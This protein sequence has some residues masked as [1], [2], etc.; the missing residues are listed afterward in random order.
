M[1]APITTYEYLV[2]EWDGKK[3]VDE[4]TAML[5][6]CGAQGWR[7]IDIYDVGQRR[8]IFIREATAQGTTLPAS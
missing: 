7:L 4:L 2:L 8:A 3:D 1:A 6:D 5:N